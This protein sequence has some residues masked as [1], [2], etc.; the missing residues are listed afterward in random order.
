LSIPLLLG[1]DFFDDAAYFQLA[2]FFYLPFSIALPN[3]FLLFES[4]P[5]TLTE[6]TRHHEKQ[7]GPAAVALKTVLFNFF[8]LGEPLPKRMMQN[9]STFY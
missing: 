5:L 8:S 1:I 2:V 6:M 7:S 4:S 3:H 9:R